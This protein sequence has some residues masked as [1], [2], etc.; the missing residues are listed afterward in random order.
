M[1]RPLPGTPRPALLPRL[2]P[3]LL[4]LLFGATL[5]AGIP[6]GE[7][8]LPRRQLEDFPKTRVPGGEEQYCNVMMVQRRVVQPDGHC[9]GTGTFFHAPLDSIRPSM[10]CRGSTG[11]HC[12]QSEEYMSTECV[13]MHGI[14]FPR[15]RYLSIPRRGRITISS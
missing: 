6:D 5:E 3:L 15:C 10:P 13:L 1:A 12:F 2:L 8:P 7:H 14:S 9:Q 11:G 4:P